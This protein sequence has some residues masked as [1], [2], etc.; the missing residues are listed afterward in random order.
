VLAANAMESAGVP[1]GILVSETTRA[2]LAV[3]Q[4]SPYAVPGLQLIPAETVPVKGRGDLRTF[5]V[6]IEG[7]QL[8]TTRPGTD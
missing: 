2:A 7:M 4:A 1:G 5:F 3:M 6:S 8:S